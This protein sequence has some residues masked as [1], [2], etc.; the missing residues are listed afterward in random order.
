V[1]PLASWAAALLLAP[2]AALAVTTVLN[3]PP[4]QVRLRVGGAGGVTTVAFTLTAANAGS[5]TPIN[6]APAG[7]LIRAEARQTGCIAKN[8]TLSVTT[9]AGLTSGG[10]TIPFS[11][12]SWVASDADIAS[13]AYLAPGT[14]TLATFPNCRRVENT[15]AF[16]F[17]NAQVYPSGTYN[18]TATYTL[19]MP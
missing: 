17:D 14:L 2:A 1:K 4:S 3:P 15:H 5:G 13:G 10:N 7:V 12:I 9:P 19:S 6:G 11:T 16:S 18:G 8:A